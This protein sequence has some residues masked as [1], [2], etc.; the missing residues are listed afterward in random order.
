MKNKTIIA[1][2]RQYGSG[3]R[4]IG[5]KLAKKLNIP[6]YDKEILSL[7]A[8]KSGISAE[9]LE[10]LDEKPTSSLLYS[11]V[12]GTYKGESLPA[13]HKLF[14]SQF[15][16]IRNIAEKGPSVIIGRCADYILEGYANCISV[17]IHA[18]LPDRVKRA[19]SDYG[20]DSKKAEA[21]VLKTDKQRANY[22]NFYTG[23]RWGSIDSYHLSI[24]SSLMGIDNTVDF[25]YDFIK[26]KEALDEN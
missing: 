23:K 25:I 7:A 24:D 5:E 19:V 6:F 20:I 8:Q 17:F 22:Y 10:P 11:L 15:E 21:I 18:P 14:L 9:I 13:N 1:L 2:G 16:V 4:E 12:V 3:G 26:K